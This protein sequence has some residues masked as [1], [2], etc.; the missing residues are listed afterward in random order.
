PGK[1][2]PTGRTKVVQPFEIGVVRA[3]HV[4]DG[5][6]VKAGDVLIELDPTINSAEREHSSADLMAAEL[7][8]APL[9]PLVD[10]GDREASFQPPAGV[11]PELVATQR[12]FLA[13]QLAEQRAKLAGL[14][15]QQAQKQAERA[16]S[17]ATVAK[18]E[19]LVPIL[20]QQLDVR[21]TLY[22]H[23]TGS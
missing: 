1:I 15:R 22:E 18:I 8:V 12:K 2:V 6:T 5:Q 21:K 4:H 10:S 16:T 9:R 11:A 17:A 23:E 3:I 13:D 19:A 14:D 20:Q 7:E